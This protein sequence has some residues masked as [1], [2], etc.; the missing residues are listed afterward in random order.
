MAANLA[1]LLADLR[2][3]TEVTLA[4]VDALPGPDW[5]RAT[6]ASGWAIRDQVSHL[7]YFDDAATLAASAPD[8]FT[9]QARELMA[10]GDGFPDEVAARY[11]DLP[12]TELLAWWRRARERLISTF[13]GVD[14]R[15]R[16]PW[17]GPDMSAASSI[18]ARLMETWAH[19]QDIADTL[20]VQRE[21]TRRLRNIAHL[22]VSTFGFAHTLRGLQV[23]KVGVRVALD[24]PDAQRWVWGPEDAI[25]RVEGPALDFC[26]VVTQRRHV[27]DTGLQVTGSVAERWMSIAQAFAGAPGSGRP[28][29]AEARTRP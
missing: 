12:S 17:Y 6:P 24:A 4:M 7:A 5:E 9:A 1:T 16:V 25:D 13:S 10:T 15:T 21:A 3:E 29:T 14:P 26:L 22:G 20:G 27:A 18:T 23:P 19:G 11:R 2:A 8:R 28:P